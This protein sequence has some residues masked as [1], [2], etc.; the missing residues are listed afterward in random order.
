MT[1][2]APTR[3]LVVD[4]SP[5]I[6]KLLRVLLTSAGYEVRTAGGADAALA[7][8]AE[9]HPGLILM[10]VQMPEVDGL[11]LT[12]RLK[13]DPR[14]RD[15]AIIAVTA[16]AMKGDEA[17]VRD[18]GCDGYVTKPID[19]SALLGV[20]GEILARAPTAGSGREPDAR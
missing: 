6:V 18:A 13:A 2:G 7:V 8:L 11:T 20:I 15:I 16:F 14:Y 9:F 17:R 4:D 12:R 3:V 1:A 10:D 19:T 5:M